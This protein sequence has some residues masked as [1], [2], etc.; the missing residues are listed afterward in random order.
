MNDAGRI[1][2]LIRGNYN[3]LE[4]YEFLDVVYHNGSSYV[5][6]KKT[7]G[8]APEKSNEYWQ[9]LAE[10]VSGETGGVTGV[11]GNSETQFRKGNVNITA[12]DIGVPEESYITGTLSTFPNTGNP[13]IL[14]IDDEKNIIYRWDP[15]TSVYIPTGG[16]SGAEQV[17]FGAFADFPTTG[18]SEMLYVDTSNT[19]VLV[20]YR[21]NGAAYVPSGGGAADLDVVAQE[22]DATKAYTKGTYVIYSGGLYCFTSDKA[23]GAWDASVVTP[24]TVGVELNGLNAKMETVWNKLF[25]PEKYFIKSGVLQFGAWTWTDK[26][27][28]TGSAYQSGNVYCLSI[29]ASGTAGRDIYF[30]SPQIDTD[31]LSTLKINFAG[32]SNPSYVSVLTIY[33]QNGQIIKTENI[34]SGTSTTKEYDISADESITIEAKVS[35]AGGTNILKISNIVLV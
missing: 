24:T 2:F 30:S 11:K 31:G 21:W 20:M 4:T 29:T 13:K 12:E 7:S 18:N 6:R 32:L 27:D 26:S 22:F 25:P 35:I 3:N 5:A 23:A 33:N 17:Y 9:I 8:N 19:A 15:E 34:S 1:G 28:A 14:Y 16:T 10:G